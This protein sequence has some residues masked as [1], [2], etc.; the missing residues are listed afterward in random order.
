MNKNIKIGFLTVIVIGAG[1]IGYKLYIKSLD[2]KIADTKAEL[3]KLK[4]QPQK[5]ITQIN[6]LQGQ[7]KTLQQKKD[8]GGKFLGNVGSVGGEK[9]TSSRIK[10]SGKESG[11]KGTPIPKDTKDTD[12]NE[13]DYKN[14]Y[15]TGGDTSDYVDYNT[16][17]YQEYGSDYVNYDTSSD[18]NYNSGGSEEDWSSFDGI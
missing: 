5:N 12:K 6:K 15:Y 13:N 4:S 17:D 10:E 9:D 3:N 8:A 18:V 1:F 14:D 7:L 16:S 2:K 11:V